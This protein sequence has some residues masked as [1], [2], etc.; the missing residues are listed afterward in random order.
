[1]ER[2]FGGGVG[3]FAKGIAGREAWRTCTTCTGSGTWRDRSDTTLGDEAHRP[4][5]LAPMVAQQTHVKVARPA[6]AHMVN[7]STIVKPRRHL[8]I[9]RIHPYTLYGGYFHLGRNALC[10][11][12]YA[13][14]LLTIDGRCIEA[15]KLNIPRIRLQRQKI[16]GKRCISQLTSPR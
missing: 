14:G 9:R 8:R 13:S 2:N 3:T 4:G 11:A 16:M 1:M 6:K 7:T 15:N 12:H 5:Q 10:L